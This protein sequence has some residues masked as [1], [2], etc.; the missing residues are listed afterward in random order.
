M[1]TR[2]TEDDWTLAPEIFSAV[3]PRRGGKGRDDR[4]F[5]EAVLYFTVHSIA[6][7]ALPAEFGNWN[8]VGL[9]LVKSVH[10]AW[11]DSSLKLVDLALFRDCCLPK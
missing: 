10:R 3:C 9:I 1:S 4:R 11:P 7:R 2:L 6:W 8:A 5:L